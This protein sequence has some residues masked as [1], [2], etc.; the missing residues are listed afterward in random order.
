M[1]ISITFFLMMDIKYWVSV[2]FVL[3]GIM[4]RIGSDGVGKMSIIVEIG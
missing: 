3:G 1:K 4:N 2:D